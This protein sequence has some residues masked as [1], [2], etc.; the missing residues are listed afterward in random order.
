[1]HGSLQAVVLDFDGVIV[2]SEPLHLRAYQAVLAEDGRS[3]SAREYYD[4][5]VGLDDVA[6]FTQLARAEGFEADR[7][8]LDALM[9]RK[10]GYVQAMLAEQVPLFPGA[11]ERVREFA[12]AVPV[13]VASGALRHEIV[14]VLEAAGLHGAVRVIVA[15]GETSR[16]KPAPDPYVTAVER[17]SDSTG[18][19]IDP[20]R[21]VAVEDTLAGLESARAA[22]LRTVGVTTTCPSAALGAADLV[23]PNLAALTLEHLSWLAAEGHD[24]DA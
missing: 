19:A 9:E 13:A 11:V 22:G 6:V 4:R 1:V 23:V 20:R 8:R 10:S 24:A 2:N 21:V 5:Y 12:A 15:A 14:Q 18:A 16:G 3:L 17:L 7:A